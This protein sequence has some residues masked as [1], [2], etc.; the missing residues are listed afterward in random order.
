M[1]KIEEATFL[2]LSTSTNIK[3]ATENHVEYYIVF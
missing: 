1:N 2:N 3:L